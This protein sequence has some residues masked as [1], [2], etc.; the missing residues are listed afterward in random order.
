M[1]AADDTPSRHAVIR[2]R[3]VHCNFMRHAGDLD[4]MCHGRAAGCHAASIATV[5]CV[6]Y[7]CTRQY[8]S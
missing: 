5:V 2:A 7:Q 1:H 4:A 8:C 3:H 6:F